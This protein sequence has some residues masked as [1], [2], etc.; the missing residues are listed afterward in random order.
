MTKAADSQKKISLGTWCVVAFV[1]II[2]GGSV[3]LIK[4]VLSG[5][6]PHKKNALTMVTLL[7]PPPPPPIKE[8]PPELQPPKEIQKEEVFTQV[9][10]DAK[11]SGDEDNAPAGDNLGV[12]A[13][14]AAG[15]DAF[16]LVGKKGGKSLLAGEG[17][18]G[19]GGLGRL[20]LMT[21]FSGYTHMVEAEIRKKVMKLLDEKGGIPKGKLQAVARVSV[22]AHGAVVTYRI[23]GSSGD[24]KMDDAINRAL[25]TARISA[26]PPDGMPRTM[27]VRIT[28]QG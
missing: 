10:E 13:E 27:V 19:G 25:D 21:K 23:I 17:G 2:A 16:G 11:P 5:E 26:P 14:G 12:D 22:D 24:H 4:T 9:P 7:K 1:V 15:S 3:Y 8:K 6:S 28:S 18:P 20:S